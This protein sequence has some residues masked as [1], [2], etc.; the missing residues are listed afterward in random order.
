M[1][2]VFFKCITQ[3]FK[4]LMGIRQATKLHF[5]KILIDEKI[6]SLVLLSFINFQV[7]STYVCHIY[8]FYIPKFNSNYLE[9]NLIII[10]I[11]MSN[12]VL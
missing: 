4:Y 3:C 9:N 10:I 12:S 6:D 7:S 5:I 2:Y 11:H 1:N 8:P